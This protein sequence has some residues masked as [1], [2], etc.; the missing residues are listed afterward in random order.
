MNN[1]NFKNY[2][3]RIS[4]EMTVHNIISKVNFLGTHFKKWA[5]L[6][7]LAD[8]DQTVSDVGNIH[9]LLF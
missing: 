3:D 7:Q 8:S 9:Q 1:E 6:V 2:S 4:L 5:V